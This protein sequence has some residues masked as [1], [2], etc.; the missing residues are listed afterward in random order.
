MQE[1]QDQVD[2]D[3]YLSAAGHQEAVV[4]GHLR[5]DRAMDGR[6]WEAVFRSAADLVE[7][8]Q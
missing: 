2:V 4:D 5:G 6:D 1:K 8:E 7:L 3:L